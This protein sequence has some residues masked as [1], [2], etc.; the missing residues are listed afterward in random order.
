MILQKLR[1]EHEQ[2]L[3]T[4][5]DLFRKY[6]IELISTRGFVAFPATSMT[7]NTR[8]S[9]NAE[10]SDTAVDQALWQVGRV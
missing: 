10:I 3:H 8:A 5:I 6:N 1:N 4:W 7:F 9:E 2:N